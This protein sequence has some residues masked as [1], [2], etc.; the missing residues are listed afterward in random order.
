MSRFCLSYLYPALLLTLWGGAMAAPGTID[1]TVP[2]PAAA[3]HIMRVEL[4]PPHG[5]RLS[6]DIEQAAH[7]GILERCRLLRPEQ[8]VLPRLTRR[9]GA[10]YLQ[11]Y[12]PLSAPAGSRIDDHLQ[13]CLNYTPRTAF[14]RVH[15]QSEQLLRRGDIHD[16]IARYEQEMTTWMESPRTTP[17]P[18][19]APLP[20]SGETAGYML[21][22]YPRLTEDGTHCYDYLIVR[23]PEAARAEGQLVTN[24][25]ISE[26]RT[27]APPASG[28]PRHPG[29]EIRLH[30]QAAERFTALTRSIAADKGHLVVVADGSVLCYLAIPVELGSRFRLYD[31]SLPT[32]HAAL[33]PPLPCRVRLVAQ[34]ITR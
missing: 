1:F 6:P 4:Q 31:S 22:E 25:D 15:P 29:L 28:T 10:V 12:T 8:D 24:H 20:H 30:R 2:E 3:A 17:P 34:P 18:A 14:L 32:L 21:V 23:Q 5:S 13:L 7:R 27:V 16:I 9:A 11:L 19:P 26:C 33:L